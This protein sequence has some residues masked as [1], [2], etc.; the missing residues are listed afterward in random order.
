MKLN[1]KFHINRELEIELEKTI[2]ENP[3]QPIKVTSIKLFESVPNEGFHKHNTL[4][5]IKLG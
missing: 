2:T 4:A 1:G 5:K 3:L